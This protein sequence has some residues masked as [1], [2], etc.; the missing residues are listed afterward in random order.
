MIVVYNQNSGKIEYTIE[1]NKNFDQKYLTNG[2]NFLV[3]DDEAIR[4]SSH[5]VLVSLS[6]IVELSKSERDN[7]L[8][9]RQKKLEETLNFVAKNNSMKSLEAR[10]KELERRLSKS[11]IK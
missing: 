11:N 5:K 7:E 2:Q 4:S 6:K 1:G 9:T 3:T 10:V 8:K